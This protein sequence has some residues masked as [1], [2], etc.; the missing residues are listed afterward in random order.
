VGVIPI[1]DFDLELA[2]FVL[3]LLVLTSLIVDVEGLVER[4]DV[5]AGKLLARMPC[6]DVFDET[7]RYHG[8]ALQS[9]ERL[10][11]ARLAAILLGQLA[12]A[13]SLR[14]GRF[15]DTSLENQDPRI[16]C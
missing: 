2:Q 16:W 15:F 12:V 4:T 10:V 13:G 9:A 5:G 14:L 8:N 7:A 6:P 3:H 1:V 11:V